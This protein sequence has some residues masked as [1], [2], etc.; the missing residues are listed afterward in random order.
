M[1]MLMHA[2]DASQR[3][4]VIEAFLICPQSV[5]DVLECEMGKTG[6]EPQVRAA[7]AARLTQAR[8][9][10]QDCLQS[11]DHATSSHANVAGLLSLA[12]RL[13]RCSPSFFEDARRS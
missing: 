11:G 12:M 2:D 3:R 6:C 10:D 7:G 8:D 13:Q 1:R 9:T 4:A 5:R